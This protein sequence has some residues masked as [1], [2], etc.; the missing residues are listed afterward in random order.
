M[1]REISIQFIWFIITEIKH[2]PVQ[3]HTVKVLYNSI[4][5]VIQFN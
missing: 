2:P 1:N 5:L 4:M 3:T